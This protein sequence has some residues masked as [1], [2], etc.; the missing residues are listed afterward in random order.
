MLLAESYAGGLSINAGWKRGG[1]ALEVG[2]GANIDGKCETAAT[3]VFLC[4]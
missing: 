4:D 1:N 2:V 3:V